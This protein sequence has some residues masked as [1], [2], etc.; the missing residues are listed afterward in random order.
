MIKILELNKNSAYDIFKRSQTQ[1]DVAGPVSEIIRDVA[2]NGDAAVK[3]Y[4][5]RHRKG[6]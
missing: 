3:K 1:I 6:R 4:C 2:E 5:W